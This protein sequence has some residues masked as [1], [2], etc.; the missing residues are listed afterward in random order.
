MLPHKFLVSWCYMYFLYL[1]WSELSMAEFSHEF[2]QHV[3]MYHC[4]SFSFTEQLLCSANYINL[5]E[6]I[7]YCKTQRLLLV[8]MS[9]EQRLWWWVKWSHQ[10]EGRLVCQCSF[11]VSVTP[12]WS[13][14]EL[15]FIVGRCFIWRCIGTNEINDSCFDLIYFDCINYIKAIILYFI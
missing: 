9:Q 2:V 8:V 7:S 3:E 14:N 13:L 1:A 11:Q 15:W 4:T 5:F 12:V 6:W 10:P